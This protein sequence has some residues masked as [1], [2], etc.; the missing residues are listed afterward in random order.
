MKKFAL[1]CACLMLTSTLVACEGSASGSAAFA[2]MSPASGMAAPD[3]WTGPEVYDAGLVAE[4]QKNNSIGFVDSPVYQD[5]DAKV[6]RSAELTI[7]TTDFEQSVSAL[8]ALTEEQGGYYETAQVEGG[9][10]NHQQASRTAYYV[11][12]VPKEHFTAF[13]DALGE[14][15]HLYSI[16]E[17]TKD[18]GETYYDTEARL[19]TLTTKRDRLLALLEKAE[20][21]EDIIS[22]ES[23]LADVQYEIDSHTTTLRKYDSL[24][25]FSAFRIHLDEVVKISQGVDAKESFGVRLG[26]SFQKGLEEFG[27]GVE[28]SILWLARNFIGVAVFAMVAI[29]AVF[30]GRRVWR[31]RCAARVLLPKDEQK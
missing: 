26:A 9:G 20:V 23:A 19:T 13:R 7:Q 1:V 28:D 21:M 31:K 6:I 30:G 12:R 11:V 22:L 4:S 14:V 16:T 27:V 3:L 10:I 8:A 2:P 25:D 5:P 15:G 17:D 18:V 24:I 29:A